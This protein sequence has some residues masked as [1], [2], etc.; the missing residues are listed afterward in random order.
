MRRNSNWIVLKPTLLI[1]NIIR[2]ITNMIVRMETMTTII[3][4]ITISET[5]LNL[6][7]IHDHV[8]ALASQNHVSF[9]R[10]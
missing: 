5:P 8:P 2:I 1:R 10:N 6:V 3:K 4:G 7:T 9:A